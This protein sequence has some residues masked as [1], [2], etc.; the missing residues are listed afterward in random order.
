M[1]Q[2]YTYSGPNGSRPYFVYTPTNYQVGVAVPLVVM[3]HGCTQKAV[4]LATGTQMNTLAEQQNFIV[5]YPQQTS[6]A[7]QY[8][9]WNWFDL[10]NQSRDKGE[11]SIIAGIVQSITQNTA[12]WS[13]DT[14]RIYVAGIS[15]GAALAVI[16]GATY[17]D[18]FA[19]IGVHAGFEY[20]AAT[21]SS[22]GLRAGRNGGPDPR[23]QGLLA[24]E[25]MN[26]VG[27]FA[28]AVPT[29]V[30]HGTKDYV[31]NIINGDQ[32]V[33]QWMY[34]DMLAS[35]GSYNAN[36]TA[37]TT[38]TKGQVPG[39]RSY[40]TYGWKD[41]NSN[42]IQQYWKVDG[43][44]HAWSGGNPGG[45]YT[46]AKGPNASQA[47][48]S[49]FLLHSLPTVQSHEQEQTTSFWQNIRHLVKDVL[50]VKKEA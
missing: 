45:S 21:N 34:T 14:N 33:Q 26:A 40:V 13:I 47:I 42:E 17:P 35:H 41:A 9:C 27:S 36:F 6:S 25:A 18:V 16:L 50:H 49:F 44:G 5:V 15:A 46:D 30:F 8:L 2:E 48:Y 31:I 19:A 4:D 37:P 20:Q 22:A 32:T 43:M 23:Q 28:R 7:N 11:P 1:W 10:A 29:I 39:G 12:R 3:L 38:T 24:Y